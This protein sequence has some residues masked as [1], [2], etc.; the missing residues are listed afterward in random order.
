MGQVP[1][2]MRPSGPAPYG[3]VG[4]GRVSRHWRHYFSSLGMPWALWSCRIARADASR[5]DR[6]LADCPIILLAV[7]DDAIEG[8]LGELRD[9][10]LG[11]RTF[12]HFCGGRSIE[13]AW[14]A[15][16]LMSFG[17]SLYKPAFYRDI[18]IFAESAAGWPDPVAHFRALFP[19][20]PNPCF[21]LRPEDKAYYHAICALAGGLTAVV[22][23]EFFEA[24]ATRFAVP[25]EAL[26]GYPRR[27]IE[28]VIDSPDTALTG[29]VARGDTGTV[30]AHLRALDG[31]AL[32][33]L[34]R[35]FIDA[36]AKEPA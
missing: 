9:A 34:Y 33:A 27:I 5:A 1:A 15:H 20:L 26:A 18:P 7:A 4:D 8:V 36:A 13:G 29:P 14:G 31:D 2:D 30:R 28:N 24:M 19:L 3:F 16:P 25:R 12:L 10:G 22:W 17:A 35:A 23:R 11:D 21:A 6:V 32:G